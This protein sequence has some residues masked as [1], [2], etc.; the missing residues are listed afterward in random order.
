MATLPGGSTV[1]G[2]GLTNAQLTT[3][4]NIL[5]TVVPAGT[6]QTIS[7]IGTT[8]PVQTAPITSGPLLLGQA[9]FTNVSTA[10]VVKSAGASNDLGV[11]DLT[12]VSSGSLTNIGVDSSLNQ[13]VVTGT[14]NGSVAAVFVGASDSAKLVVGDAGN[15]FMVLNSTSGSNTIVAGDGRDSVLGGTGSDVISAN[16]DAIIN[17]GAGNDVLTGGAGSAT[18]GGGAGNDT[19]TAGTGG[20]YIIGETGNDSLVAGAGKDVFIF[21]PG[22]GNDTISG[23]NPTQDTLAFTTANYG[24]GTLNLVSLISSA[25]V[26]GGNTVLTLPD[27]STITV[28]GQTG[29]SINWFTVK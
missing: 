18:L 20:G 10:T 9:T 13:I 17:G 16:G 12:G 22:D 21:R 27:G 14:G 3:V 28:V 25:Q 4:S 2:A 23:F 1:G 8:A 15:Q 26:T 24:T 5:Q 11:V 7:T 6:T 29:A 19:I